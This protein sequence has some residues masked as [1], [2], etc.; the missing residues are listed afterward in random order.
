MFTGAFK[1]RSAR[2]AAKE[3]PRDLVAAAEQAL[4]ELLASRELRGYTLSRHCEIGPFLIEYMFPQHSL[5]VELLPGVLAP[6]SAS[7]S[8]YQ[9]RSKFLGA[10]GYAVL[11][12]SPEEVLRRPQRVMAQ[13]RAALEN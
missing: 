2:R 11:V 6:E 4:A 13:L 3:S 10:M 12:V 9:A 8:R 7:G 5:I 1:D